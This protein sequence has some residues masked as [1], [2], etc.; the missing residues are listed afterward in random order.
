M[1][2]PQNQ[3][4]HQAQDEGKGDVVVGILAP[5]SER[6]ESRL[7]E[8]GNQHVLAVKGVEAGQGKDD[9]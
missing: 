2:D 4:Q 9:E 8:D 3:H 1:P 5:G 6:G 7:A